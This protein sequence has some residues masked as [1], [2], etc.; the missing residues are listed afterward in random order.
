[1]LRVIPLQSLMLTADPFVFTDDDGC[2]DY[3]CIF[4]YY[5]C[6]VASDLSRSS[7]LQNILHTYMFTIVSLPCNTETKLKAFGGAVGGGV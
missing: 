7:L 4:N 3:S 5:Y 6:S 1:M 2:A